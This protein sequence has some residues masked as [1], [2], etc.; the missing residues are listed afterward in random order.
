MPF[1]VIVVLHDSA[2]ELRALLA[3]MDAHL[4]R[5]P[6][7]I[8]VDTG[9]RDDGL[10][11]AATWGARTVRLPAGTGFGAACNAGLDHAAER[12]SVLANPD[13]ELLDDGLARLA[14]RAARGP[15]ALHAPRLLEPDGRV[16]RSAHP[17]PGTVGA[18]AGALVHAPLLPPGVRVR[19]EPHRAARPRSV[20][21]AIAA[22]LAAATATFRELGPF[23]PAVPLFAEDMD[24]CLR[25]REAGVPTVLHPD[26]R[27][28]H[29]GGHATRRHGEP[30]GV[31][32]RRRRA[33]LAARG[34]RVLALDDAAQALTFASR[35]A[36]HAL[37]GGDA[38]RPARQLA[39]LA[40]A[41]RAR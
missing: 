11:L 8:V 9:S 26:L 23:D 37:L 28:R 17:L 31:L 32:A 27:L 14:Q 15:E 22:C 18:L 41:T 3:S 6:S 35:A 13:L 2:P 40:R 29:V 38:G 36:G 1:S 21:W 10:A 30:F 19:L 34:R 24:L 12:V 20:G 33:V 39:A 4:A 25:A 5:R 16:Q 7:V